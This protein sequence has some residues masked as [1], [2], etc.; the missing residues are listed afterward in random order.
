VKLY[1]DFLIFCPE[2]PPFRKGPTVAD[3]LP[4]V[5]W[6]ELRFRSGLT[7]RAVSRSIPGRTMVAG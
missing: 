3:M 2:H 4:H 5:L 7:L 1:H 6:A